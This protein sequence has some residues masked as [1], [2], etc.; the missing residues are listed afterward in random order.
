[1]DRRDLASSFSTNFFWASSSA[2]VRVCAFISPAASAIKT[3]ARSEENWRIKD[4]AIPP[5]R[6]SEWLD[7]PDHGCFHF[8]ISGLAV[9]RFVESQF[10]VRIFDPHRSDPVDEPQHP[11]GKAEGPH[12]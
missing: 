10:F 3:P 6:Q 1:M 11:E 9:D 5:T 7:G 8:H 12:R 4:K 2:G